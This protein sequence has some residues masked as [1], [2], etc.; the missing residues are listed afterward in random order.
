MVAIYPPI[1]LGRN[2]DHK[3]AKFAPAKHSSEALVSME[4]F[5]EAVTKIRIQRE[6]KPGEKLSLSHYG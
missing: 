2:H 1:L 3:T 4:H 6:M 5:E